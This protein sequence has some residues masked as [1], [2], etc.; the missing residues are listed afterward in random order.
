MLPE[1]RRKQLDEIVSKM[2]LNKES[3]DNINLVVNDFKSKYSQQE[4]VLPTI[5]KIADTLVPRAKKVVQMGIDIPLMGV[6]AVRYNMAKTPEEKEQIAREYT[7]KYNRTN[8]TQKGYGFD[9]EK[10]G[11][12]FDAGKYVEGT[13]KG[14]AEVAPYMIPGGG[15]IPSMAAKGFTRAAAS[16]YSR[17]KSLPEIVTSGVIGGVAEPLLTIGGQKVMNKAGEILDPVVSKGGEAIKTIKNIIRSPSYSK[18]NKLIEEAA[19]EGTKAG[20]NVNWSVI[21]DKI[22][23][24]LFGN[25]EKGIKGKVLDTPE[26]RKAYGEF[27]AE[28]TPALNIPHTGKIPTGSTQ[29]ILDPNDLLAGR[30]QII[31][32]YGDKG[33]F[34]NLLESLTGKGKSSADK[35]VG[36]HA[37]SVMTEELKKLVPNIKDPDALYSFYKKMHGDVP[38]WAKRIV[39]SKIAGIIAKSIFGGKKQGEIEKVIST[40]GDGF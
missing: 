15:S 29:P 39:I 26:I 2:T 31:E 37:R 28:Q 34:G 38:T 20:K 14:A 7:E 18:T 5:G 35:L 8:E 9:I 40:V 17:D 12:Q 21:K 13:S 32:T 27:I 11:N 6:D 19:E 4:G 1:D 25:S 30:R 33:F 3:D 10:K 16:S 24:R 22:E 36:E 23:E